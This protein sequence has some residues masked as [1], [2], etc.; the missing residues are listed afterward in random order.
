MTFAAIDFE[1]ATYE[2]HSACAV[3]IVTVE[4][5]IISDEYHSLIQPPGNKYDWQNIRVHGI[6]PEDTRFAGTFAE[7]YPQIYQRLAGRRVIA[8]NESFDRQVLKRCIGFYRLSSRGLFLHREWECTVKLSR[9]L[10]FHPNKLSD[11]CRRFN[12][13]LNHHE[14]L[15]DARACALLYLHYHQH[16]GIRP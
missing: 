7:H 14:A 16:Y 4:H 2:G 9:S 5:G 11:C 1:T 13:P 8:H 10:G 12:I 3:G 6:R 15:S